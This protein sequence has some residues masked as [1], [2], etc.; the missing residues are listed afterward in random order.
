M[1]V[2]P[3]A[4]AMASSNTINDMWFV[5][6]RRQQNQAVRTALAGGG[7]GGSAPKPQLPCVQKILAARPLG[8]SV[9]TLFIS[10]ES[11]PEIAAS[12][13]NWFTAW[14]LGSDIIHC[15][16]Y[17]PRNDDS[18]A[19]S[20]KREASWSKGRTYM[21]SWKAI[22]N[23]LTESQYVRMRQLFSEYNGRA[24]DVRG[25]RWSMLC[26]SA[27]CIDNTRK[28]MCARM[29]AEVYSHPDVGLL[30]QDDVTPSTEVTPGVLYDLLLQ[31]G[32]TVVVPRVKLTRVLANTDFLS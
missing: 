13:Q 21:R 30:H 31:S 23:K 4:T 27:T 14:R 10:T 22:E 5:Q 9:Q 28:T 6:E 17:F 2:A 7:G 19:V 24:F 15:E 1:T 29:T 26:L 16:S 25:W 12:F 11:D 3:F 20:L 32:G 8:Y 18:Y